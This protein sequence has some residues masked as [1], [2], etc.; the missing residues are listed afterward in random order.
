MNY[1]QIDTLKIKPLEKD[2]I[3]NKGTSTVIII[4][5]DKTEGNSYKDSLITLV[6]FP[7]ILIIVSGAITYLFNRNMKKKE[8]SKIDE[9]IKNLKLSHQPMVIATLQKT[10]DYI[11]K[12]KIEVL[13]GVLQFRSNVFTVT[14]EFDDGIPNIND[15]SEYCNYIYI[16]IENKTLSDYKSSVS[17]KKYF[18]KKDIIDNI[19]ETITIYQD[20][21]YEKLKRESITEKNP[22]EAPDDFTQE[23]NKIEISIDSLIEMIRV[24]LHLNNDFINKFLEDN[25]KTK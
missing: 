4:E 18:F 16:N 14:L 25:K 1:N 20:I 11:L 15:T 2:T 5:K 13:K 21:L 24:D 17:Q 6:L 23:L 8:L 19:D 7:I 10:Q 12:D 3:I 22:F 9:E